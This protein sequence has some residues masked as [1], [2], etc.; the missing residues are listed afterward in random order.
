[1]A[2]LA[3]CL[4]KCS[5]LFEGFLL[6]CPKIRNVMTDDKLTILENKFA[7]YEKNLNFIFDLLC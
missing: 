6:V 1:M 2:K 4:S 5:C 7:S 3:I